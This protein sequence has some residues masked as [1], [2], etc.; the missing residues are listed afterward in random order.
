MSRFLETNEHTVLL[1]L[2]LLLEG[3]KAAVSQLIPPSWSTALRREH[4]AQESVCL[5]IPHTA[6]K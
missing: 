4:A 5:I 2:L 1:L 6:F 3:R